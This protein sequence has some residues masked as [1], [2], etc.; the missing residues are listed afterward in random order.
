M[1]DLPSIG[2]LWH[3]RVFQTSWESSTSS[4]TKTGLLDLVNDPI[5][6]HREDVLGS[7]PVTSLKRT[8]DEGVSIIVHI[9]ENAVLIFEVTI[10]SIPV[11]DHLRERHSVYDRDMN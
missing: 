5:L 7:V 10:T 1:F 4:A 8:I 11:G 2:N 6:A 9:S 3:E